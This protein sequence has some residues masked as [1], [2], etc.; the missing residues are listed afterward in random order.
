[1]LSAVYSSGL[2]PLQRAPLLEY[3]SVALLEGVRDVLEEDQ[4]EHDV[5]VLGGVHGT[6][7]CVRRRPEFGLVDADGGT[8]LLGHG[9]GG[10]SVGS[11][12]ILATTSAP[13]CCK[14]PY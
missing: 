4:A 5:L 13:R 3:G 14:A 2:P 6:A 9:D 11:T 12:A 7:Q 1:M 8:R 10:P